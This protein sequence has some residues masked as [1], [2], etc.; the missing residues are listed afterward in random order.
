[1]NNVSWADI[2]AVLIAAGALIFSAYQFYRESYRQKKEST[3]AAY[4]EL[5]EDVFT[6]L[7]KLLLNYKDDEENLYCLKV[8]DNDWEKISDYLARIERFSVGIN[9]NIYCIK[10][11]NRLG[12][13]YYIRLFDQLIPIIDKKRF[14][15]VSKGSHY[16]EFEMTVNKLKKM[17]KD[18]K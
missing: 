9:S 12:G 3:L 11:L 7:N 13:G 5:Q 2:I 15:N 8:G 14:Y 10:T 16:D 18:N 6:E 17:R 4:S 1:M